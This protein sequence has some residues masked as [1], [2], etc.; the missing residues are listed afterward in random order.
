MKFREK[1]KILREENENLRIENQKLKEEIEIKRRQNARLLTE[2]RAN[3]LE[4]IEVKDRQ[5]D[6]L[7]T[8]LRTKVAVANSTLLRKCKNCIYNDE[9][10]GCLDNS[11]LCH[12]IPK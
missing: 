11:A 7:L 5:N 4:A 3:L 12:Y 10:G 1:N 6:R 9:R 2:L 8:E